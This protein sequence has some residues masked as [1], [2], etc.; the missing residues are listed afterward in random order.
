MYLKC[1]KLLVANGAK[2]ILAVAMKGM[3]GAIANAE[4]IAAP[5]MLYS[6]MDKRVVVS[7]LPINTLMA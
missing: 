7:K 3:R 5:G 2:L 6:G 1:C 4:E